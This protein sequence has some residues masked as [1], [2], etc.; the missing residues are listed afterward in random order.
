[1]DNTAVLEKRK[2]TAEEY[3]RF[4]TTGEYP[5]WHEKAQAPDHSTSR[6][7]RKACGGNLP[8]DLC[9]GKSGNDLPSALAFDR[10][11]QTR[12]EWHNL[13]TDIFAQHPEGLTTNELKVI[14]G[15]PAESWRPR[16][17]EL[18]AA[19]VVIPGELRRGCRVYRLVR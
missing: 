7:V 19:G 8:D 13:L 12:R 5:E 17:T 2:W 1:M 6:R 4:N 14:L 16:V 10:T 15:V 9:A 3:S 18:K 11:K